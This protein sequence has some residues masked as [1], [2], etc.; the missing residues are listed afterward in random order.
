MLATTPLTPV[1]NSS[2]GRLS[3]VPDVA[4]RHA[5]SDAVQP[6]GEVHLP[7]SRSVLGPW[8][9]GLAA[10]G[11]ALRWPRATDI[12]A[13]AGLH[14]GLWSVILLLPRAQLLLAVA[15]KPSWD[16]QSG[17][18][19]GVWRATALTPAASWRGDGKQMAVPA[20]R[21]DVSGQYWCGSRAGSK[22]RSCASGNVGGLLARCADRSSACRH[23]TRRMAHAR[24]PDS[25]GWHQLFEHFPVVPV[26]CETK[27]LEL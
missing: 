16:T 13:G 2:E 19:R 5:A 15:C 25:S 12:A 8:A 21:R 4:T 18:G 1:L 23:D 20:A 26:A 10:V 14:N 6:A 11:I 22:A 24:V 7:F 3:A 9:D 27:T 17:S